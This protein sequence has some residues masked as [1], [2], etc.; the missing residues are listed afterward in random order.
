MQRILLTLIRAY[1]Y[2]LSPWI[3]GHCRFTPTCSIYAMQ[4]IELYGPWRGSWL[5]A[6]RLLRCH[7][8]CP[9]GEDPVPGHEDLDDHGHCHN[10]ESGESPNP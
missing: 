6:K 7:P 9:G 5:A 2:F 3:G 8:L 10:G 1:R 4:A